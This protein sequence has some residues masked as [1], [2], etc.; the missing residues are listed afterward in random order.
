M[1]TNFIVLSNDAIAAF[2]DFE[3]FWERKK[4]N[5]NIRS[6]SPSTSLPFRYVYII[7][8]KLSFVNTFLKK[9]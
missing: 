2:Y 9:F 7:L 6:F 5:V 3:K 1:D 8:L 4:R